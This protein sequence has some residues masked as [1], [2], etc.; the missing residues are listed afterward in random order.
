MKAIDLFPARAGFPQ[1]VI[2]VGEASPDITELRLVSKTTHLDSLPGLIHLRRLWCFAVTEKRLSTISRCT[3]LRRLYL[4]GVRAG[5]IGDLRRLTE[6]E[7]L[8]IDSA[9]K[10]NSLEELSVFSTLQGL[11]VLN[12]CKVRS[13]QPLSRMTH[14]T[15]LAVAGGMWSR[16]IVESL[17]PLSELKGLRYLHL[18]NL[19]A[20][21]A[22]LEPLSKL[23]QLDTLDLPNFYSVAEF[24]RLSARLKGTQCTWFSPTV[25]VPNIPCTKCAGSTKVILAG[26]GT[27]T[28]C[29]R[30]DERKVKEH[31]DLFRTLAAQAA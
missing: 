19:K 27:K 17:L 10:L 22:T 24:A 28:L 26:R 7:V 12:S 3:T 14:L 25:P 21:D 15:G 16:V 6:L 11:A 9:T 20:Q 1:A 8:S 29:S 30:C 4:D 2:D 18:S 13:L 23:T 5:N 31:E